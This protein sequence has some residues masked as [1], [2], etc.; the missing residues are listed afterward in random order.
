MCV[1][2]TCICI[3]TILSVYARDRELPPNYE[4]NDVSNNPF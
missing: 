3:H 1:L 2:S 4:L